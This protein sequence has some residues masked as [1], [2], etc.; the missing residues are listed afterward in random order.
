MQEQ[1]YLAISLLNKRKKVK[2]TRPAVW[3]GFFYFTKLDKFH[4]RIRQT[5]RGIYRHEVVLVA[6]RNRLK[7]IRHDYR[8]DQTE[9]SAFLGV[10]KNL[11]NRWENNKTQP[12]LE[13]AMKIS[14]ITAKTID[15]FIYIDS[16]L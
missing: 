8:M 13:W 2:I 12:S 15:S 7:E 11:Y 14:K 4:R 6:V 10:N 3:W 16:K 1:L 9:F 5:Q